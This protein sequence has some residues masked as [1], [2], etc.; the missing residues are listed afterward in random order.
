MKTPFLGSWSYILKQ[1]CSFQLQVSLSMCDLLESATLWKKRLW[2]RC[3]PVSFAN[4]FYRTPL[5]AASVY[6]TWNSFVK[7]KT[8]KLFRLVNIGNIGKNTFSEKFFSYVSFLR[9][10]VL[11]RIS[12]A[13]QTKLTFTC[14]KLRIK[15]PERCQWCRYGVFIIKSEQISYIVL[16][17]LLLT[18]NM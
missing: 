6:G 13:S 8:I 12:R 3:F 5:V 17:F 15:T 16:A 11:S 14:S 7:K 2:H 4:F 1:S 9:H 10:F 18:L